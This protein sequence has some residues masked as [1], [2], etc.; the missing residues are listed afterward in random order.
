NQQSCTQ[1]LGYVLSNT[2]CDDTNNAI[3]PNTV[4]Y[5]DADSDNYYTGS[6]VIQ[7][8]SPGAGYRRTGLSGGSDCND[9]NASVY[10]NATEIC[11]NIDDDCDG[12][13][14][15]GAQA[16]TWYQDADGDGFGNPS[17]TQ[18]ACSAPQGYV[19]DNTDCNDADP[20]VHPNATEICGNNID[21]NCNDQTDENCTEDLPIITLRTYPVKE[22]NAGTIV[23]DAEVKLDRPAPLQIRINYA[24]SNDDAIAGLDY[25]A[26]QGV[27]TIPVGATSGTIPVSI[28]GDRLRENNERFWLNFTNPVNAII[29][30]D[31][32]SRIMIIDDDKGKLNVRTELDIR[33]EQLPG[34]SIPNVVSRNHIWTIT[35]ISEMKNEVIIMNMQGQVIFRANNYKN[36]IPIGNVATGLYVYQIRVMEKDKTMK[37][38]TGKLFV[39][40]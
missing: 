39:T 9:A 35:A 4:W 26:T 16:A 37:Y 25:V 15:E 28:I 31:R 32:R 24:T 23:F 33:R 18:L 14:D 3:N 21:D 20:S 38:Y 10:P 11:N 7:C 2:D 29:E 34:L 22:G 6:G 19:A 30:G 12:Q 13:I 8:T 17:L 1:P 40:E 5:L 27:L 36:N